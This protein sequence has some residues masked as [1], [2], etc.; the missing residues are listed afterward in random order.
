MKKVAILL[1]IL[2]VIIV[3]FL[4]GYK[5]GDVDDGEEILGRNKAI[6]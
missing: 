1:I 2:M 5:D 3:G 6:I 4:S